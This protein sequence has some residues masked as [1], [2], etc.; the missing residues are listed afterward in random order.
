[1]KRI[2]HE[3]FLSRF[4]SGVTYPL[5]LASVSENHAALYAE[6]LKNPERFWG[7]LARRR[8]RWVKEFDQVMDCNMRE[9][10]ISWFKGG[11]LNVTG[12]SSG[13]GEGGGDGA[14]DGARDGVQYSLSPPPST[15]QP[16]K[17]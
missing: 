6:S 3:P 1:M 8:L 7:D 17:R 16:S 9:G 2:L 12:K 15:L 13:K 5:Q 11:M 10:R 4:A 14:R